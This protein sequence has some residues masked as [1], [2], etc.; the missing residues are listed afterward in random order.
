PQ[1]DLVM[2]GPPRI[3]SVSPL[4][5]IPRWVRPTPLPP[6][7]HLFRQ[8]P[9]R[10]VPIAP[11]LLVHRDVPLIGREQEM[12]RLWRRARIAIKRRRP[13]LVHITG[14]RGIGRSRL[15]REFTRALEEGGLGEG[16]V[17]ENAVREGPSLGLRGAWRRLNP[18]HPQHRS[19]VTEIATVLA[20]DRQAPIPATMTEAELLANWIQL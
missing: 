11:S 20:R 19:Y 15:V 10:R 17:V 7:R 8:K 5:D 18:P 2:R 12:A 1:T 6:P 4:F 3:K 16:V 13:A 9:P 14:P